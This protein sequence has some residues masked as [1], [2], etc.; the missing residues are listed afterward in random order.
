MKGLVN[1]FLLP[2]GLTAG[3]EQLLRSHRVRWQCNARLYLDV[4]W[5]GTPVVVK[6]G[7]CILVLN[8]HE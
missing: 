8:W 2:A 7:S 3:V 4:A 5:D 6:D 1:A